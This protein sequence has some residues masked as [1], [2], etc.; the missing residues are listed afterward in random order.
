M[1]LSS[2]LAVISLVAAA[3]ASVLPSTGV[4]PVRADAAGRIVPRAV[5]DEVAVTIKGVKTVGVTKTVTHFALPP[6][7]VGAG[8]A[9]D[10]MFFSFQNLFNSSTEPILMSEVNLW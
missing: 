2:V 3:T 10:S 1:S 5:G 6:H 4:P 9:M 8:G 7:L